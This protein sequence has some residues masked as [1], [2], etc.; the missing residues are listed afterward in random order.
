MLQV[1]WK[2]IHHSLNKFFKW[3]ESIP[4][5]PNIYVPVKEPDLHVRI[6]CVCVCVCNSGFFSV[7][8]MFL[9]KLT[10]ILYYIVCVSVVF[11]LKIK[12]YA[13]EILHN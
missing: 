12:I 2:H 5:R 9:L 13:I 4:E 1:R 3:F 10:E 7:I 11:C 6:L 8:Y